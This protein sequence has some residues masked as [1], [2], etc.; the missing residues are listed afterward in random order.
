[1]GFFGGGY[2]GPTRLDDNDAVAGNPWQKDSRFTAVIRGMIIPSLI[3]IW[4]CYQAIVGTF[5]FLDPDD[6]HFM[7]GELVVAYT[8]FIT[9][10]GGLLAESGVAGILLAW[11]ALA[12][13]DRTERFCWPVAWF[14]V[15]M[16][17]LGMIT[18]V[19][20]ALKW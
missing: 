8:A 1:M 4:V 16:V 19:A 18:F 11:Y 6:S 7:S 2:G 17:V 10:F 3:L 20:G 13:C 14:S 9:V 5:Y 12:N 15:G